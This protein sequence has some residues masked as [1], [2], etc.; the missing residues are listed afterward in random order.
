MIADSRMKSEAPTQGGFLFVT[1]CLRGGGGGTE[2][3]NRCFEALKD[4][5]QIHLEGQFVQFNLPKLDDSLKSFSICEKE[6]KS[7]NRR[8]I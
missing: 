5:R 7:Q 6:G 2:C 3:H 8:L 4:C 1:L